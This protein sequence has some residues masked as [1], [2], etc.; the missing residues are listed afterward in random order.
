MRCIVAVLLVAG[1]SSASGDG[2]FENRQPPAISP[3]SG[4][5]DP[6]PVRW[7]VQP[8]D[9]A[10]RGDSGHS[11]TSDAGPVEAS[12]EAGADGHAHDVRQ[13]P[14]PEPPE[15]RPCIPLDLATACD[16]RLCGEVPNGCGG[17][18]QCGT[19]NAPEA[20]V[21]GACVCSSCDSCGPKPGGAGACSSIGL[22]ATYRFFYHC[23]QPPT[24]GC[25]LYPHPVGTGTY[26]CCP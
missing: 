15:D 12:P 4:P 26:W 7:G 8:Q 21:A 18:Y 24:F 19:C 17:S 9:G 3:D 14:E 23:A 16:G 10:S 13:E 25:H 22:P 20:C 6:R 1:C 5:R 11:E 2:L